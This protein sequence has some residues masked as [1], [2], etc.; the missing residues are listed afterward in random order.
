MNKKQWFEQLKREYPFETKEHFE[1]RINRFIWNS[2]PEKGELWTIGGLI[3]K[4]NEKGSLKPFF[5][6]TTVFLL[7][8]H[9]V[10]FVENIQKKLYECCGHILAE[11]LGKETFHITLHDLVNGSVRSRIEKKMQMKGFTAYS[12]L[13]QLKKMDIPPI[14]MES[15]CVFNMASTSL[16][17]GMKPADEESYQTWMMLY[18]F[19]QNAVEL[20][21]RSTPHIT[22]A[23][24]K[25]GIYPAE[26]LTALRELISECNQ[27]EKLVTELS[28]NKLVYQEFESMNHYITREISD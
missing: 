22:L 25:P 20:E 5:G 7:D 9:A 17:L 11:S 16:V 24:Y 19:F 8:D 27:K 10:S 23:Y 3:T 1:N 21:Y 18:E 4:V 13:A 2:I 26:E 14:R 15:T 12:M 28:I 6:N